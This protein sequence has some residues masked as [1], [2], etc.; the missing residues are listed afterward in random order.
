[1][2][3]NFNL[4]QTACTVVIAVITAAMLALGC[5]TL[6]TGMLECAASAWITPKIAGIVIG[7]LTFLKL[8]VLPALTPGGLVRNLIEPKVP[9]SSS[10]V[11]GT[12]RPSNISP[13]RIKSN[14]KGQSK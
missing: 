10:G 8:I 14:V 1:M 5:T 6:P 11:P 7:I 4:V 3:V 12:V 9:V 2:S 13:V